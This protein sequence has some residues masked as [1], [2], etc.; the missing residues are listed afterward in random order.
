MSERAIRFLRRLLSRTIRRQSAHEKAARA[1]FARA[2]TEQISINM[3]PK[4]KTDDQ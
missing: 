2:A 1:R 4:D 3:Q